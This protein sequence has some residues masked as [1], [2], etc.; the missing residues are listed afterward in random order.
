MNYPASS[1][2]IR[3][4]LQCWRL[5]RYFTFLYVDMVKSL[6]ETR[7][8]SPYLTLTDTLT[9]KFIGTNCKLRKEKKKYIYSSFDAQCCDKMVWLGFEG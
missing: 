8:L 6:L 1:S 3:L 7:A 9:L 2:I 5:E 4:K